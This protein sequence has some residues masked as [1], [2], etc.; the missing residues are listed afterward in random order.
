[1]A[2]LQQPKRLERTAGFT[3]FLID[4]EQRYDWLLLLIVCVAGYWGVKSGY[5]YPLAYPD[6]GGYVLAAQTDTF[7]FYRP[8]GYSMF[9]Q[10]IHA[11]SSNIHAVFIGQIVLYFISVAAFAFTVKYFFKPA[12]KA[13]WYLLLFFFAFSPMAFILANCVMSDLLFGATVFV[14]LASFIS[15][16]KSGKWL[17]LIIFSLSLFSSLHIRYSAVVFP[18]VFLAF[19]L[20][21]KG[22]MRWLTIAASLLVTLVFHTQVKDM[23]EETTRFRQFST[24][25]DGWQYANNG[26]HL[27]PHIKDLKPQSITNRDVRELHQFLVAYQDVIA[28]KTDCGRRVTT[29]FMWESDLPLKMF[30]RKKMMEQRRPYSYLWIKLGSTTYKKYGQY[31]IM[32]YPWKFLR[33]YYFPNLIGIFHLNSPGIMHGEASINSPEACEWYSLDQSQDLSC[34]HPFYK[35]FTWTFMQISWWLTWGFILI[36]SVWAIAWRKRLLFSPTDRIVFWGLFVFG[37]VYYASTVFATPLES[38]YLFPVE[39]IN[40]AFCYLLFNR[41]IMAKRAGNVMV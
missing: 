29:A 11:V 27:L 13:V 10:I 30:L 36:L 40:F 33:Y 3:G 24:G 14:L 31:L 21:I 9:L 37:A 35:G 23:M 38:R 7:F 32:R 25:F 22:K 34:K 18:V 4:K 1:M 17:A 6:S 39:C 8:F 19:A 16:V 12:G 5:P 2:K 26:M 41:I 28:E 15:I 20:L